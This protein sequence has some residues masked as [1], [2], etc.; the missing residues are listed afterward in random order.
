MGE[1]F[2]PLARS[3]S[4][5]Y[6]KGSPVHFAMVELFRMESTGSTVVTLTFKNLYSRPVSKLTIHYRCK[7]QAG[8]VVGEDDFDYQNVGAP[9]GACFGGNDGVFISD[10]P[11]SSVDVNLVSVVY[12]DGILHSLK[13][14]GPVALPAPRALPEPVKNALCT[15]M[16]SRFLRY[17]P[18]DLTD[19]WQC[20]CG[21]FNY[22]AGKGKTKC[23]ECGVDRADLFAAIQGI[24]A[25]NAGQV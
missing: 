16:N 3:R 25:H 6:C 11:L 15:A 23:T 22:N 5:Y 12:D 1:V 13:R 14:C 2:T 17:Y 21:A 24:A 7:N 8:A 9:E 19:G 10:E 20:A 18:A 4:S